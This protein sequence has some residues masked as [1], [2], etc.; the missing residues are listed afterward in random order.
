VADVFGNKLS[1]SLENIMPPK[2]TIPTIMPNF[3]NI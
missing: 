1:I 2:I 3:M